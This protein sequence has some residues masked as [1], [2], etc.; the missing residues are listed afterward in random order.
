[1]TDDLARR[2]A[3]GDIAA[4]EELFLSLHAPL[5]EVVDSYVRSQ[6]V[7]E[8]LVQDLFLAVWLR[9]AELSATALRGYLFTA[10]RNR[11]LHHLRRQSLARRWSAMVQRFPDLGM[12]AEP[13]ASEELLQQDEMR[14]ALRAAMDA[15]PAR[16]RLA[17]VLRIDHEMSH[18]QIGEA[19]GISLKAVEKLLT[20][21]RRRLRE[22]LGTSAP[23]FS[24]QG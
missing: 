1:M 4:F 22:I 10:A 17:V 5:C 8:E 6:A 15:L 16:T 23:A 19:M 21:G 7:A 12:A 18:A 2:I 24:D 13:E 14:A 11:A 3:A 20:G 9:R